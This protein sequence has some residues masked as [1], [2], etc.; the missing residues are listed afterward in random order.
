MGHYPR[1]LQPNRRWTFILKSRMLRRLSGFPRIK[2]SAGKKKKK[3]KRLSY[4]SSRFPNRSLS[5]FLSFFLVSGWL[6]VASRVGCP[7][8]CLRQIVATRS[9][10]PWTRQKSIFHHLKS[11]KRRFFSSFFFF[12]SV[13]FHPPPG[14][15]PPTPLHRHWIRHSV[16]T[17]SNQ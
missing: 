14:K 9:A 1:P 8:L 4:F 2:D 6:M 10:R 5:S 3:A 16:V 15:P 11:I 12:E 7:A 13:P 17:S